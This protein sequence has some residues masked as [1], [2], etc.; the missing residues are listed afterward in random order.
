MLD[1]L[2]QS[3][4]IAHGHVTR[5]ANPVLAHPEPGRR[6]VDHRRA[7][8]RVSNTTAGVAPFNARCGR[9]ALLEQARQL[10]HRKAV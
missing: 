10:E 7:L 2:A 5:L 4:Q 6:P 8:I 9:S 1:D 3:T